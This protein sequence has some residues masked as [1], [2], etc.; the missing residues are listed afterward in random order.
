MLRTFT[1]LGKNFDG[2]GNTFAGTN[3]STI[4]FVS[5][6]SA[7]DVS[8][9]VNG[10]WQLSEFGRVTV[11]ALAGVDKYALEPLADNIIEWDLKSNAPANWQQLFNDAYNCP[12][13]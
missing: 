13:Y 11:V 10:A 5:R 8:G 3:Y 6:A 9:A 12:A 4:V 2:T 7:Q 1:Q